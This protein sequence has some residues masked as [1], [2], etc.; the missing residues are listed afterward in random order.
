MKR[1]IALVT[2][3]LG[4]AS[5]HAEDKP[6]AERYFRAGAKAYAAQNFDAAATDFDE[7]WKALPLPE[8]AFSAAQAYRKLYRLDPKP[9]HVRRAVELYRAYLDKVK[10]GGRVGDAVDNLAE[11]ERELDKLKASGASTTVAPQIEHTRLGVSVT[12]AGEGA[13]DLLALREVGDASSEST[14][15]LAATIDGKPVPPFALVDVVAKDHVIA[16]TAEGYFPVEKKVVAVTGQSQ[17]IELDLKPRPGKVNVHTEDGAQI[18]ID[19]RPTSTPVDVAAGNHLLTIVHRGREPYLQ[20]LVITRGHEISVS[21]PLV[22][23]A[24]RRAVPWVVGGTTIAAAGAIVTGVLAVVH[25][26]RASKL[27]DDIA[28]GNQPPS[29]ADEYDREVSSR[30]HFVTATWLLG[31]AA[32]CTGAVALGLYFFDNPQPAERA[33]RSHGST[34]SVVPTASSSGGGLSLVG[35]FW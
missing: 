24:R 1:M 14:R 20:D 16:A 25:D 4:V 8:I 12:V 30:D 21:A 7:A 3:G 13:A 18:A 6:G 2:V 23:T 28:A 32:A 35:R 22:K 33:M 11:M 9:Q 5:A 29:A 15:G 26:G 19:G 27:R 34:I 10:S 31:G 17:L